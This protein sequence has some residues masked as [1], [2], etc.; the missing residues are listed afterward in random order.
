M[1]LLFLMAATTDAP[2]TVKQPAA[3]NRPAR[4]VIEWQLQSAP[5][6]SDRPSLSAAEADAIHERYLDSIGEKLAPSTDPIGGAR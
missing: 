3:E 4:R 5:R 1:I 6:P 2:A